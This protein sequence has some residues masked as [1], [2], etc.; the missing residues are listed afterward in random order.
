MITFQMRVIPYGIEAPEMLVY[1]TIATTPDNKRH[2]YTINNNNGTLIFAGSMRKEYSGH[3]NPLKL[4]KAILD[5]HD[6]DKIKH[7]HIK[8]EGYDA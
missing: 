5:R 8:V 6:V 3:R 2:K 7:N 4:M 1:G